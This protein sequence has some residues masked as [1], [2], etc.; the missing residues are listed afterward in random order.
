M[1]NRHC[2]RS[3]FLLLP[4]LPLATRWTHASAGVHRATGVSRLSPVRSHCPSTLVCRWKKT[5][6]VFWNDRRQ[7][8]TPHPPWRRRFGGFVGQRLIFWCTLI[9]MVAICMRMNDL[10]LNYSM[11]LFF[12]MAW[13]QSSMWCERN[14]VSKT[15]E[16]KLKWII[17]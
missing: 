3:L 7:L 1:P 12:S 17:L 6:S 5:C 10:V 13:L 11:M 2:Y 8:V 14:L 16:A 9:D 15:V 4:P